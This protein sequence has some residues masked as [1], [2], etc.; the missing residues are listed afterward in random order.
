MQII[1]IHSFLMFRFILEQKDQK[2]ED[3]YIELDIKCR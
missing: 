1:T 2:D 3:I